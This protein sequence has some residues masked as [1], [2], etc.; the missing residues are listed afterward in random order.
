MNRLD[1]VSGAKLSLSM[2]SNPRRAGMSS[3]IMYISTESGGTQGG[4]KIEMD[5]RPRELKISSAKL[6][7]YLELITFQK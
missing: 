3:F 2:T 1:T 7:Q 6:K 5:T 4:V